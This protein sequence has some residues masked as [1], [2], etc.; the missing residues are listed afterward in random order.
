VKKDWRK[1]EIVALYH[2][3]KPSGAPVYTRDLANRR[4][5]A[6]VSDIATLLR[7]QHA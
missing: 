2:E 4:I 5:D 6:V 3:R 1:A 7:A